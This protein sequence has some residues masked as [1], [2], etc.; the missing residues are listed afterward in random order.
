MRLGETN[1]L[2]KLCLLLEEA[3]LH[4]EHLVVLLRYLTTRLQLANGLD[5]LHLLHIERGRDR[6]IVTHVRRIDMPAIV[7]G[8]T[9][10]NLAFITFQHFQLRREM[11]RIHHLSLYSQH[12]QPHQEAHYHS[13]HSVI[14]ISAAK[15]RISEDN[16]K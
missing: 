12:Y 4:T 10:N 13:F 11:Y 14:V 2:H 6:T 8:C 1:F 7:Y 16:T 3:Q 9:K 5:A 15:V